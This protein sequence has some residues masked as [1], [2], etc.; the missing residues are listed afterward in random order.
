[1]A[2]PFVKDTTFADGSGGGTPI[3]AAKLN[4]IE[5]GVFDAHLMPA[6]RVYHNTSQSIADGTHVPLAFNSERFDTAG[7]AASTQHDTV[8]NNT[9]L[10]CRYA[11]KYMI[12]A[13]VQFAASSAGVYRIVQIR[14]NGSTVI[15]KCIAAA[16]ADAELTVP[17]LYDLAINDYVEA[18]ALQNTGSSMTIAANANSSPEFWMVRV[19]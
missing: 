7:G 11:G 5:Q 15:G 19:A 4:N 2:V 16:S 3:T 1:M 18:T 14:L 12:G 6:V 9:R 8:T 13:C 10:T 17:T